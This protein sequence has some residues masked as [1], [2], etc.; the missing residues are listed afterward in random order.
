M[1]SQGNRVQ[2]NWIRDRVQVNWISLS[3]CS[4]RY[5]LRLT[6]PMNKKLVAR[7]LHCATVAHLSLQP[8]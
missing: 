4:E 8:G 7:T 2:V 5:R 6:N 3:D 1:N